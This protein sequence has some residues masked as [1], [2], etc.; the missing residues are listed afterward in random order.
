[1]DRY[2]VEIK[3]EITTPVIVEAD[4]AHDAQNRAVC[5]CG[6]YGDQEAGEP[7]IA[8]VRLI[9]PASEA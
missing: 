4:D 5:G 8:G 3:Q 7:Q 9:E 1:M 6:E 2:L